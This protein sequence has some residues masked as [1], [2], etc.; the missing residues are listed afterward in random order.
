M[1]DEDIISAY[2]AGEPVNKIAAD[3][4]MSRPAV[5]AVL[6]RNGIAPARQ[7][8]TGGEDSLSLMLTLLERCQLRVLEQSEVI[9]DLRARA[10]GL[11]FMVLR[12][13]GML[14]AGDT[15]SAR[16]FAGNIIAYHDYDASLTVV[17]ST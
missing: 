14:E 4:L 11:R 1:A 10:D 2:E 7:A 5:Y 16:L 13:H 6:K 17:D 12:L 3:N 15:E 9:G 8:A